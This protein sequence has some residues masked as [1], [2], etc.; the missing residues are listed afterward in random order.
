MHVPSISNSQ[1]S[2]TQEFALGG[3]VIFDTLVI[4]NEYHADGVFISAR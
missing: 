2:H 4:S 1:E 3:G